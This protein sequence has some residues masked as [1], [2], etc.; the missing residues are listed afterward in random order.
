MDLTALKNLPPFS[1]T[2]SRSCAAVHDYRSFYRIDLGIEFTDVQQHFGAIR[3]GDYDIATHYFERENAR[4]TVFFV[5]GY[6]DHVGLFGPLIRHLLC[7]DYSVLAFDLPGHGLSSGE[8]AGVRDFALYTDVLE[9]MLL[10][11]REQL[12][13]PWIAIGQSMGGAVVMDLLLSREIAGVLHKAVVLAPLVRPVQ[14]LNIQWKYLFGRYVLKQ[15]PR[16]YMDNTHDEAFLEFVRHDPLQS[17]IIPVSW[18]GALINWVPRFLR[19]PPSPVA[20]EVIQGDDETTVDWRYNLS[21]IR[22]KFPACRIHMIEGGRHHLA[23]EAGTFREAV[24]RQL[25][26]S[27]NH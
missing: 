8:R 18:V 9:Q 20:L 7:S 15:V 2:S 17:A 6:L 16:I 24:Y 10:Q 3:V 12:P 21:Q 4:G 11:H 19:A 27:L 13:E 1:L 5:H 14:W 23:N 25:D 22:N 26:D